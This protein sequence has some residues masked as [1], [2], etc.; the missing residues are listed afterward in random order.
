MIYE[1]AMN[2]V[3]MTL[4]E[5]GIIS[6]TNPAQSSNDMGLRCKLQQLKDV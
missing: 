2:H 6:I 4:S 3:E 1:N 5:S